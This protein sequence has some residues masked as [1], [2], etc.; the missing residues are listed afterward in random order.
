MRLDVDDGDA[1]R[2]KG[3]KEIVVVQLPLRVRLAREGLPS[4][5]RGGVGLSEDDFRALVDVA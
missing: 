2:S 5:V 3:M 4:L 1:M